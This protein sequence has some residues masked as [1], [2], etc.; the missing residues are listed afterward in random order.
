MRP[1]TEA[2]LAAVEVGLELMRRRDGAG[3]DHL[4]GW[5]RSGDRHRRRR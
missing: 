1:E 2:A 3:P 5:P 4:E